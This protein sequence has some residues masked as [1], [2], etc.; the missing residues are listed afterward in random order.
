MSEKSPTRKSA[1]DRTRRRRE[2]PHCG[3]PMRSPENDD[4][5]TAR[6]VESIA[7]D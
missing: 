2:D 3:R 4:P 6:P 7:D 1:R 5:Y